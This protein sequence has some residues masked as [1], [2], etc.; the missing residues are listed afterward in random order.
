MNEN[1]IAIA[2]TAPATNRQWGTMT[3]N[4][5]L[6]KTFKIITE[7]D[8]KPKSLADHT[9]EFVDWINSITFGHFHNKIDYTPFEYYKLQAQR[10][11]D[12]NKDPNK[13]SDPHLK[14]ECSIEE[15]KRIDENTL[16]FANKYGYV[17][18]GSN[19]SGVLKYIAKEHNA[20]LFYMID[21]GYCM[22]IG[23]PRQIFATTTVGLFTLKRLTTRYNFFMKFITSSDSKAEEILNDKYKFAYN[24]IPSWMQAEVS[25]DNINEFRLG[26]RVRKGVYEPPN[27]R[28]EICAPSTTA[29]NGG[30]PQMSLIDEIGEVPQLIETLMEIRPTLF[31]D[32]NQDGNLVLARQILSWGTGVSNKKGKMAFE[33][34]WNQCI[35]LWESKNYRAAT[36]IPIFLSWH[37]RCS[38]EVYDSERQA[39]LMGSASGIEQGLSNKDREALFNMH[40]PSDFRDMFGSTSNRL[41]SKEMIE[42]GIA[43]IRKLSPENKPQAGYFEPI[44]DTGSPANEMSDVPYKIVGANWI[45]I[46]DDDDPDKI[47][48]YMVTRPDRDWTN[49][50]FQGTDPIGNETGVSYMS[51][52]IWDSHIELPDGSVTEAPVCMVYHRKQYDPK[53]SYL[54]C[55]LMGLYYDTQE[56][57]KGVPE[58]IENNIGTNYKEYKEN[59]GFGL[60]VVLNSEISDREIRGGGAMWGINTSGRGMNRRKMKVVGKLRECVTAYWKNIYLA[61]IWRELETYVNVYKSEETWQ[62]SDKKIYRDDGIDALSFS[63]ICRMCYSYKKAYKKGSSDI[64]KKVKSEL[65]RLPNGDL[66]RKN[67]LVTYGQNI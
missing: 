67:R 15:L 47:T 12:E 39:Y 13:Y 3:V 1:D 25:N 64:K 55:V 26:K 4:H 46:D 18:E 14:Q 5:S 29:I 57:K 43:R 42:D 60:S 35:A 10:W 30:A 16:Y 7:K 44:Y 56:Q 62:P 58:L 17:K 36:F 20:F 32:K 49:R 27:S 63:Y 54:Q 9:P 33:Q 48:A 59:K 45:P 28:I 40:Y 65:V 6:C 11:L 51:S 8:W 52:V 41:I 38:R 24:H 66:S 37:C 23:K 19:H 21:C 34:F 2:T 31:V 61:I 53:S 22:I 50:Y